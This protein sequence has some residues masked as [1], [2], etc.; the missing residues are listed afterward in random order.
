MK[1]FSRETLNKIS[2]I[3]KLRI[4]VFGTTLIAL[5]LACGAIIVYEFLNFRTSTVL[6]LKTIAEII[7]KSTTPAVFFKD[8]MYAEESLQILKVEQH[9][10]AI[11]IFEENGTLFAAY[12]R[13][14]MQKDVLTPPLQREGYQFEDDYVYLFHN[15]VFD[16]ESLATVCIIYELKEMQSRLIQY[17]STI[18]I[19]L[20]IAGTIAFIV[21]SRL[22]RMI[23]EPVLNL[24]RVANVV[25][26]EKNY[27]VRVKPRK[28][29]D[30]LGG[31]V[32]DFNKML[33]RIE[34]RDKDLENLVAERTK[35]LWE[36]VR[37]LRQLD[38]MKTDFFTTISHELRT[39]LTSVL[40][41]AKIIRKR[42][43]EKIIPHLNEANG[44]VKGSKEGIIQDLDIILAEGERLT[45]MINNILDL[46]KLE[47]GAAI[48]KMEPIS[49]LEVV[50]RATTTT[51][52]MVQEKGLN[53]NI[54][55]DD[56][57][58]PIIGDKD[59]LTQ[60]MVNLIANA[61]KYTDEGTITCRLTVSDQEIIVSVIDSGMGVPYD[62]R[63]K[64]FEKFHQVKKADAKNVN[65]GTGL[66]L[67]ICKHI[68]AYH[69]GRIWLESEPGKGS[70]FSFALP[71]S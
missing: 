42:F 3:N 63:D 43:E 9:I 31:L 29:H 59:R 57:A 25:T 48:W 68:V 10:I 5:F 33:D 21:T 15:I 70:T 27:S 32:A 71:L 44:K 17:A 54:E 60:V 58:P 38:K 50:G 24:A 20:L 2:F 4:V 22:Q 51:Y 30:E 45:G 56:G 28:S 47:E 18:V 36:A 65:S 14:P 1:K 23:S 66:G 19:V 49:I 61:V 37:E 16:N 12:Y 41:F 34:T 11:L 40:G 39:P 7:G 64:L 46:A 8:R 53:L 35:K 6:K 69:K 67:A 13:N 62:E 52:P 55:G 26:K